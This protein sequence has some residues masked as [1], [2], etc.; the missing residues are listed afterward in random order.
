M[1]KILILL[2]V[3]FANIYSAVRY[4]PKNDLLNVKFEKF[5]KLSDTRLLALLHHLDHIKD[6]PVIAQVLA[7]R[8]KH[9]PFPLSQALYKAA[10]QH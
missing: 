5:D 8:I 6:Q 10:N 4:V 9:G 2:C 1:N 7:S 3:S